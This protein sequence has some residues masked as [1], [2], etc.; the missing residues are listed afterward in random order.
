M[1]HPTLTRVL[2]V[3]SAY[4]LVGWSL[5]AI[6]YLG[7]AIPW[8]EPSEATVALIAGTLLMFAGSLWWSLHES[9][10]QGH[11]GDPPPIVEPSLMACWALHALGGAGLALYVRD[12]AGAMGGIEG[13]VATAIAESYKIRW[14]A[15]ETVSIGTQISYFGWIAIGFSVMRIRRT[16]MSPS[17]VIASVIQFAGNLLFIDRTRPTWIIFAAALVGI[18]A[19]GMPSRRGILTT[20]GSLSATVGAVFVAL[21]TW[22]G[23][24]PDSHAYG[25]SGLPV[26]LQNVIFYLTSGF[27]Y[28]NRLLTWPEPI[29]F[30]PVRTLS[31]IVNVLASMGLLP[32]APSQVNEEFPVPFYTNVG[33]VLEPFL[34]DGGFA[35]LLVGI[36][37]QSFFVDWVARRCL[38]SA[39]PWARF[40]WATLCFT[41]AV[42]FF[43][44]KITT[45]PVWLFVGLGVIA[46]MRSATV[47]GVAEA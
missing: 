34:R 14:Q 1:N 39:N 2:A 8:D 40:A 19:L 20:L 12:F 30:A 25:S 29:S 38:H 27:A 32:R 26:L 4:A 31:P 24:I 22:I 44:P 28:L 3:P 36:A 17:L 18:F 6:L 7:R 42:S 35:Y 23:K 10:R 5:S 13:F 15:E 37:V 11:R 45:T 41:S 21:A 43:T 33:T 9:S 46:S 16:G 47:D